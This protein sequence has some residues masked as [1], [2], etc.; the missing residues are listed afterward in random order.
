MTRS[1]SSQRVMERP[2]R[3]AGRL[4]VRAG[5]GMIALTASLSTG[6][7]GQPIQAD[8]PSG[9]K[10]VREKLKDLER[11]EEATRLELDAMRRKQASLEEAVDSAS[12]PR[13]QISG[14]VDLGFFVPSG[15]GRGFV[16]DARGRQRD[17]YPGIPWVFLGD[18]WSTAVNS[19]G[20][21]ADT[22]G[23]QA[24]PFDSIHSRGRSTFLV[25]E[26]NLD[27]WFPLTA[28]AAVNASLDFFPRSGS[29]GSTGDFFEADFAFLEWKPFEDYETRVE[30]GKFASVFGFEY[31][32][33]ESTARTG[34][35]PSLISRYVSGH[36]IGIK[37]RSQ[38]LGGSF[39]TN[40]AVTNGS[41][42]IET[43]PFG[44]ELDS[45]D[46][47]SVSGR[48]SFDF[49]RWLSCVDNLTLG[50]SG[51]WGSQ[52]RQR[53]NGVYQYQTGADIELKMGDLEILL[54]GIIGEAEGGGET[55]AASLD[56]RGAY[57]QVG[58][59]L[60]EK[61]TPYLRSDYRKAKH[62]GSDFVY[63][64]DETR[65]TFGLRI[66]VTNNIAW[67][68][69][70]IYNIELGVVPRIENDLFTTSLVLKF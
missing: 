60:F 52:V 49:S 37:A 34:I 26:V 50:V 33:E 10:E 29:G 6:A 9:L 21:P 63:L 31:R 38:W 7:S 25:N 20:E 56:F 47:K 45:N 44:E 32:R 68:A 17:K 66:D 69:E 64:I 70:Y 55:D 61:Y 41:S 39:I 58:Y 11:Q 8:E 51:E 35:T 18:P 67:K 4:R 28:S 54:E 57:G 24:I 22:E 2:G 40:L 1:K 59:T 62:L 42:N 23:S 12:K 15:D 5:L 43:F 53:D 36:P 3:A 65:L 27:L 30:V 13:V 16:L 14:Y 19:R 48:V 46:T